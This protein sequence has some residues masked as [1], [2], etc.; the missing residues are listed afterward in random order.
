[1]SQSNITLNRN[2]KATWLCEALRLAASGVETPVAV[3]QLEELLRVD[4]SGVYSIKKSL[5]YLRQIWLEP[6]AQLLSLR[7]E[8]LELYKQ[9]P[10]VEYATAML[11]S[12]LNR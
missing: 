7:D 1:M 9:R 3:A 5:R 2:L 4:I 10:T 12:C 11:V 6:N 8:A